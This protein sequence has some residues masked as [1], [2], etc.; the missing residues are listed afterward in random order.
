VVYITINTIKSIT[1][2]HRLPYIR[3]PQTPNHYIFTLKIIT[4]VFDETLYNFNIRRGS[5]PKA[6]L[7]CGNLR[8][9]AEIH[10]RLLLPQ[11]LI[12]CMAVGERDGKGE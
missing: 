5:T 8:T 3:L 7:S 11:V 10:I 9:R 12:S 6:E 1:I 2:T 4:A